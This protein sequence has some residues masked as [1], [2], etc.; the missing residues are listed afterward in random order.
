MLRDVLFSR[1]ILVG[2]L[3]FILIV[4]GSLFYSWHVQREEREILEK[5]DR[6]MQQLEADKDIRF[7]QKPETVMNSENLNRLEMPPPTDASLMK[8]EDIEISLRVNADV[9]LDIAGVDKNRE[10]TIEGAADVPV[11]PFGFGPY[12]SIP[13]DFPFPFPDY[14]DKA[15]TPEDELMKRVRVK[16]WQQGIRTVGIGFSN[17]T[18]LV[19]PTIRGTLYVGW[20]KQS[21]GTRYISSMKGDPDDVQRIMNAR[22]FPWLPA[23]ERDIPPDIKVLELSEGIDSYEFLNLP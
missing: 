15:I 6:I 8:S 5:H 23:R 22:E 13:E 7:A 20:G 21:D 9:N 10:T 2:F 12:P 17:R 4:G 11:S 14:F 18:Q 16:L 1:A 3:F 19:Y